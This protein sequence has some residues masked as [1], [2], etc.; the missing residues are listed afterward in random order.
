MAKYELSYEYKFDFAVFSGVRGK[1]ILVFIAI[2]DMAAKI[3]S[4]LFV[5]QKNRQKG[6]EY[7]FKIVRLVEIIIG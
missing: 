5:E 7:D 3:M 4:R 6:E 1:E 2:D